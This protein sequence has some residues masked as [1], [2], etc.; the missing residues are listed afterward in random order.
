MKE[1]GCEEFDSKVLK[2]EGPVIVAFVADWCGSCSRFIPILDQ[3]C[4]ER[5]LE[6]VITDISE[7]EDPLWE[8]FG[9]NVVP[10]MLVFR[11][12]K[13]VAR[14]DGALFNGLSRES[15][16]DLLGTKGLI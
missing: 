9:I 14:Q 15:L 8:R 6:Y 5:G 7:D 3:E 4:K 11:G 10:T 13:I 1:V 16:T 12:G 2:E